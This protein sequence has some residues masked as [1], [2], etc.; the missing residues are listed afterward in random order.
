M[1]LVTALKDSTMTLEGQLKLD[2]KEFRRQGSGW[3]AKSPPDL[4]PLAP[5]VVANVFF[6]YPLLVLKSV[7]SQ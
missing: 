7:I 3:E 5:K 1:R 4:L 2:M 6:S